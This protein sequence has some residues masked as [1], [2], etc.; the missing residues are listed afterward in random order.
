VRAVYVKATEPLTCR[1]V[2][3]QLLTERALNREDQKLLRLMTKRVGS[4][5]AR[6]A[7]ERRRKGGSGAGAV[8]AFGNRALILGFGF[9]QAPVMIFLVVEAMGL[10]DQ[11]LDS[12]IGSREAQLSKGRK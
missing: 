10:S 3:L 2:A 7:G 9:W 8:H 1:D 11:N 6:P 5:A 4:R 12:H